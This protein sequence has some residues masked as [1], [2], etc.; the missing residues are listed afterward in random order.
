MV[1]CDIEDYEKQNYKSN[2]EL[3][4]I[5]FPAIEIFV[6]NPS[7]KNKQFR[8]HNFEKIKCKEFND[9]TLLIEYKFEGIQVYAPQSNETI[10]SLV[11]H[12]KEA[13]KDWK[14]NYVI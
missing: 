5:P 12:E 2:Q 9:A 4:A 3:D 8:D 11:I 10:N 1:I 13:M 6:I 7:A 14:D